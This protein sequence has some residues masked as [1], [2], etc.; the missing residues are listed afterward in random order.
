MNPIIGI[1]VDNKENTAGSGV[2]ESNIAYSA[3]VVKA[4][5]VPVLL[6]HEVELIEHYLRLCDGFI[7]TGG[8]DPRMEQFG[9]VTHPKARIMDPRRQA[10]ETGLLAALQEARDKAVLGVCLGMQLMTLHAGGRLNQHLPD[11]IP[12]AEMHQKNNR[13]GVV[14]DPSQEV[15]NALAARDCTVVS[16]H[17]QGMETAGR[18]RV[19]ATAADGVIEAVTDPTRPFYVGVQW[20]PERG[21]AGEL[22]QTLLGHLVAACRQSSQSASHQHAR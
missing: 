2:Y 1:T 7:L 12:Q 15:F 4:G 8:V 3:A 14:L 16:S 11:T 17:R 5:G 22:N 9:D 13:H 18:L 20:H 19:I 21:G 10:F 6:P